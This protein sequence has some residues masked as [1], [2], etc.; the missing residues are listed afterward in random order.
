MFSQN[1]FLF[2]LTVLIANIF[3][4]ITGFAGTV[5]AMPFSILLVGYDVAKPVLNFL[6]VAAAIGIIAFNPK[7]INRAEFTKILSFMLIGTLSGSILTYYVDIEPDIL[8]KVLGAIVIAFSVI[9]LS[10]AFDKYEIP[11]EKPNLFLY[12][13]LIISGLVHGMFVCGGPLLVIYATKALKDKEEFRTTLSAV[14]LVLNSINFIQDI[15]AGYFVESTNWIM[16]MAMCA[17]IV[18]LLAGNFI[19]HKMNKKAFMFVT[20]ILMFI[21]GISL[22]VK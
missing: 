21:S 20:Y 5:L 19:A 14:W 15:N 8:Y 12:I 18:A 22:L 2:Y 9:G 17:L 16:V 10:S 4:S 11:K 1:S 6:G 7:A 3:H 13:L